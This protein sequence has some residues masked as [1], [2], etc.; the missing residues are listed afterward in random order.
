MLCELLFG[1]PALGLDW[2]MSDQEPQGDGGKEGGLLVPEEMGDTPYVTS[3]SLSR[4]H[5]LEP[6]GLSRTLLLLLEA[7]E[8][9]V[10]GLSIAHSLE[11][12]PG[13]KQSQ[14]C[15]FL[16]GPPPQPAD[17]SSSLNVNPPQA[18]SSTAAPPGSSSGASL[19]WAGR[20]LLSAGC[21]V[22]SGGLGPA[23]A[24]RSEAAAGR[25]RLAHCAAPQEPSCRSTP[26]GTS[27]SLPQ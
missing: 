14:K 20:E 9:P 21:T 7:G 26:A 18:S 16:A 12:L 5:L 3:A 4:V 10:T 19:S 11:A 6:V 25:E 23:E 17:V 24:V 27:G 2:R 15:S 13:P 22:H 1:P 8:R